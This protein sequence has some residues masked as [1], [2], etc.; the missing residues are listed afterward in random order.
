MTY[1][2]LDNAATTRVT[3]PAIRDMIKYAGEDYFTPSAGY[4]SALAGRKAIRTAASVIADILGEESGEIVVTSCASESNN[5]AF[6]C[7]IKN[8]KGN[9]VIGGA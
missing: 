8:K 9:V 4:A 2:Y 6:A 1:I 5:H 7:G 3:E